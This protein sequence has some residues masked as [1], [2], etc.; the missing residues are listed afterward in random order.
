MGLCVLLSKNL[1][2]LLPRKATTDI[3][4]LYFLSSLKKNLKGKTHPL[5]KQNSKK[6]IPDYWTISHVEE[7]WKHFI[8]LIDYWILIDFSL[9]I[10]NRKLRFGP[11]LDI[12]TNFEFL[13]M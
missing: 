4:A 1:K 6:N 13:L 8:D 11:K 10:M 2:L 12:Q 9:V 7:G 5:L 3:S